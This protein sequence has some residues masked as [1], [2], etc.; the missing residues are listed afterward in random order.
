M[1]RRVF[2]FDGRKGNVDHQLD[3]AG[4][5]LYS[6]YVFDALCDHIRWSIETKGP[7]HIVFKHGDEGSGRFARWL[8]KVAAG[9]A[10]Y[11]GEAVT[12]SVTICRNYG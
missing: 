12:V 7:I 8:R 3:A 4:S 6:S 9:T 11:K 5:P 1:E 2:R 10:P